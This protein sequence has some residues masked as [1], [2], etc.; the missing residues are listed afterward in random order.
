MAKLGFTLFSAGLIS[1]NVMADDAN[2]K[3]TLENVK[4]FTDNQ[5]IV[6]VIYVAG[7]LLNVVVKP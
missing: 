5:Q 7:K 6:K 1:A 3:A 2:L 4:K